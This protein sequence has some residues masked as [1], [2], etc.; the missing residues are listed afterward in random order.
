[1]PAEAFQKILDHLRLV[2]LHR[3]KLAARLPVPIED[4]ADFD[5]T[6]TYLYPG[7]EDQITSEATVDDEEAGNTEN[8]GK[9][10]RR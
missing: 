4:K 5:A 8:T 2:K 7:M 6:L 10:Q 1:M 9:R 3:K